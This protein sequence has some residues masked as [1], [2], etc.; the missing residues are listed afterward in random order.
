MFN[1]TQLSQIQSFI[2]KNLLHYDIEIIILKNQIN[3]D[4]YE[5]NLDASKINELKSLIDPSTKSSHKLMQRYYYNDI[6]MEITSDKPIIKKE[7]IV[8]KLCINNIL[9]IAKNI[10]DIS[11]DNFPGLD[12]YD[13]VM[14]EKQTTYELGGIDL[15]LKESMNYNNCCFN[16]QNASINKVTHILQNYVT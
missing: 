13:R 8:D 9:I 2:D 12:T 4:I 5:I 10:T 11:S 16:L 1:K 6:Y 14:S 3:D 7:T 15:I